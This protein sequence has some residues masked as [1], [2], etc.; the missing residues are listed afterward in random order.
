MSYK[1]WGG[2]VNLI[3]TPTKNA[4]PVSWAAV[5]ELVRQK[6]FDPVAFGLA[7]HAIRMRTAVLASGRLVLL[8]SD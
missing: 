3:A 6:R 5:F 8:S 2:V 1:T 7:K 4:T